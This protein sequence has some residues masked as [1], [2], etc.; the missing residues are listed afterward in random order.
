MRSVWVTGIAK[1][2]AVAA[3][4][5][6]VAPTGC[7]QKQMD[8]WAPKPLVDWY[9]ISTEPL[10][11]LY[12]QYR[13]VATEPTKGLFPANVGVTRVA[14]EFTHGT[15]EEAER[16]L[17]LTDPRNEFL[18]WNSALDDQMAISEV[19]PISQFDLGGGE[20]EPEQVLAAFRALDARLGLVYAMNELSDT[21]TEMIGTLYETVSAHP[22]AHFHAS[23]I[24]VTPPED[25][26]TGH[27]DL[28][29]TDS[30]AL[31]RAKFER[32]VHACMRELI[33]QDEPADVK[34]PTGWTP[35]GPTR[36]VEWPPRRFRRG[37]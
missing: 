37:R 34:A 30:K 14:V 11:P 31:V 32:L 6:L 16:P 24:S 5:L 26:R 35:V 27:G 29:E 4:S 12:D 23:A 18:Q 19:F 25:E 28:W 10:E 2:A 13:I 3:L 21:K 1:G 20:A 8:V 9:H 17:L 22:I 15:S 36:P 33:L 7:A